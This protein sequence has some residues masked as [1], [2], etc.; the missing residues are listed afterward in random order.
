VHALVK[1]IALARTGDRAL[2][3]AQVA[4]LVAALAR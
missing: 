4:A 1:Q 2:L 3:D